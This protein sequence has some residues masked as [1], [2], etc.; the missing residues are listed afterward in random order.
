MLTRVYGFRR[1]ISS[2]VY[3]IKFKTNS[4][5]PRQAHVGKGMGGMGATFNANAH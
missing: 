1:T 3:F 5:G 2:Y 4:T